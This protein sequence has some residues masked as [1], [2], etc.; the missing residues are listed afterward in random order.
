MEGISFIVRIKDEEETLEESIRSLFELKIPHEIILILHLCKDR[1]NEIAIQ[2]ASENPHIKVIEYNNPISRAGYENLCTDKESPHSIVAYSNWCFN[3][4]KYAWRFKW[5]ADFI[6]SPEL[7]QYLNW[8]GWG[9]PEQSHEL[10]LDAVSVDSVNTERYLVAGNIQF[11]KHYFWEQIEVSQ[12]IKR[13][14]PGVPILHKSSLANK[15]KYWNYT[16]WFLDDG[17]L[18]NH[19]EYISEALTVAKRYIKLIEICGPEPSGQARASN[20][21]CKDVHYK[22]IQN[23]DKLKE[24]GIDPAL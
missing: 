5:D 14:W 9:V 2:L 12:P 24:F 13:L 7:V 16:P 11:S 22:V 19:P 23:V 6:A 3:Q 21:E 18:K 15:K 10:F 4:A 8:C 1:S 20:P 17:Y